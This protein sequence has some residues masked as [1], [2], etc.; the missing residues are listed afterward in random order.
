MSVF[1]EKKEREREMLTLNMSL[2]SV[3]K[4]CD[5]KHVQQAMEYGLPERLLRV[6]F[7][8]LCFLQVDGIARKREGAFVKDCEGGKRRR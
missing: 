3:G 5:R 7:R 6:H 1:P 2:A 4:H 8:L